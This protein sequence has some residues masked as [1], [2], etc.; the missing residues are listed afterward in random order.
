MFTMHIMLSIKNWKVE[1]LRRKE[2]EVA[3]APSRSHSEPKHHVN[4]LFAVY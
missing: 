4:P 3:E 1:D 2:T